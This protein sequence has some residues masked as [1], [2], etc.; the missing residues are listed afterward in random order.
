MKGE[1]FWM[2]VFPLALCLLTALAYLQLFSTPVPL[3][4]LLLPLRNGN[5]RNFSMSYNP[6]AFRPRIELHPEDHIYRDAATQHLEWVITSDSSRPDGVLKQVFL[7]NGNDLSHIAKQA[8][9]YAN[10]V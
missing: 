6:D 5:E 7:I 4:A 1:S 10:T 9:E 2:L 3:G 8:I